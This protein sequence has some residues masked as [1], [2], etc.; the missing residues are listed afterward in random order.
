M[1][2]RLPAGAVVL[3]DYRTREDPPPLGESRVVVV[4]VVVRTFGRIFRFDQLFMLVPRSTVA[5]RRRSGQPAA[6]AS[7]VMH[8]EKLHV[9]MPSHVSLQ[10]HRPG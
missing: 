7:H 1:R 6:S 4:A 2:G 3:I 10:V 8:S 9:G 5:E